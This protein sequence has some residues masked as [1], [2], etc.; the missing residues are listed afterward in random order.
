MGSC[1]QEDDELLRLINENGPRMWEHL[2]EVWPQHC[3][4]CSSF[5]REHKLTYYSLLLRLGT[6]AQNSYGKA[7]TS[8][9]YSKVLPLKVG[10][11]FH[12][13]DS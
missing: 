9:P 12:W 10:F 3:Q 5:H 6:G 11:T 4:L 2:A 13:P 8:W 1:T 7:W